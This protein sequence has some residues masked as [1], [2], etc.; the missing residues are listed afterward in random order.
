MITE[1]HP[2]KLVIISDLHLGNPFCRSKQKTIEFLRWAV[3]HEYD[4]CING[5]GF[6]I[7]QVSFNKLARDVPDVFHALKSATNHGC[8]IYYIVGNH[9][10]ALEYFLN[11]WGGF[12]MAPF[13]NVWSNDLRVRVEHG[14]LYDPFFIRSP[15]MYEFCT[16]LAGFFLKVHPS[17]YK[18]WIQFEKLRSLFWKQDGIGIVGEHPNFV[19]AAT[20]LTER[21]FDGVVF[22]HTHHV[23]QV[24]LKNGKTYIN[25]GSWLIGTSYIEIADG[26]MELKF[27]TPEQPELRLTQLVS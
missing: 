6:E 7:A 3:R 15:H 17:I 4:I 11:D 24:Q 27:W 12:K 2:K 13:L 18:L 19:K 1:I 14:H 9:D 10:I 21:G 16:W 23:G 8:R 20:E 22:G 26:H 5:D 25:S